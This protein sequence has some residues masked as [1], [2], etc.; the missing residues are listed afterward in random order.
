M[1]FPQLWMRFATSYMKM[2]SLIVLYVNLLPVIWT[3]TNYH[4]L[5]IIGVTHNLDTFSMKIWQVSSKK[6]I[7]H[8]NPECQFLYQILVANISLWSML[9]SFQV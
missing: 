5:R 3:L 7:N 1:R 9:N 6:I 4:S 8:A 2:Q